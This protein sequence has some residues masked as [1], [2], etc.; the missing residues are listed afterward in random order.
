M[1]ST[2]QLYEGD[3]PF[4]LSFDAE[5]E[6]WQQHWT[7]DQDL[8]SQL[9]TP[10][11]ALHHADRDLY[12]NGLLRIMATLPVTSCECE[13]SISLLR[14]VKTF[15]RSSMGQGRLNGLALLHCHQSTCDLTPEKVVDEFSQ[16]HP[17][18]MTL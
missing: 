6:M 4:V 5:L 16:C 15:L 11:K 8:G 18:R 3:L 9:N 10:E 12:P 1:Q 14:L 13:H 7:A 17:W 2:L